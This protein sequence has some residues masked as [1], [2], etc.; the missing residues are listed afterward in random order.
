MFPLGVVY[1]VWNALIHLA[2][3]IWTTLIIYHIYHSQ[4]HGPGKVKETEV[5]EASGLSDAYYAP[6]PLWANGVMVDSKN[7]HL[8]MHLL[9][10]NS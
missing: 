8:Q 3:Q 1:L 10:G 5:I 7:C 6:G 9:E 2:S 4:N